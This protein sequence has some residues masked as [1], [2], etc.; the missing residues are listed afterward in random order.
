MSKTI[1]CYGD[2]NT[3]GF[4]P[5]DASRYPKNVRWTGVLQQLLG[6]DYE[7]IEEGCNGRTA[8]FRAPNEPWTWGM[9]FLT[10]AIYTHHPVD[11]LAI[12]LGTNDLKI[13]FGASAREIAAGVGK[14]ADLAVDFCTKKP[15]LVPKI[16]LVS[17]PKIGPDIC[18]SVFN[19]AF[20]ASAI[21]RSAQF[22]EEYRKE[23]EARGCLFA[24]A[25]EAAESSKI[26]SL[27]LMP[28]AHAALARLIYKTIT[29]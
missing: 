29:E 22:A 13:E 26:D 17:P 24:D 10:T 15:C 3:Y 8:A 18:N 5:L 11:I 28:E 6:D 14:L 25:A 7:V 2:S 12:M 1:L 20:D 27:H 16:L 23:A 19:D 4:N 9:D 21:T